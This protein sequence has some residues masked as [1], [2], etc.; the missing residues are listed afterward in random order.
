MK[1]SKHRFYLASRSKLMASVT[2]ILAVACIMGTTI[3]I[4]N[5]AKPRPQPPPAPVVF[6][7]PPSI[8]Q[9]VAAE[10]NRVVVSV[11][12]SSDYVVEGEYV[13]GPTQPGGDIVGSPAIKVFLVDGGNFWVNNLVPNSDYVVRFKRTYF[14]NRATNTLSPVTSNYTTFS[15]HTP[16]LEQSR[17]SAPVISFG[18]VTTTDLTVLWNPSTDNVSS[19]TQI[20]YVYNASNIVM[21]SPLLP[22]CY[23]YCFGATGL[24]IKRP[25]AGTTLTVFSLD[26]AG[27]R[28]LPSNVLVAP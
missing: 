8:I 3:G 12:P 9:V 28:S 17:P 5:A 27:N 6:V 19:Q 11:D 10:S 25:P 20:Q 21:S 18:Q 15:F 14:F 26:T 13:S 24:K 23:Q 16:T 4:A 22:T 2:A 1:I 7:A